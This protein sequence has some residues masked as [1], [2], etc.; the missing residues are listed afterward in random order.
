MSPLDANM[1]VMPDTSFPSTNDS[2][3]KVQFGNAPLGVGEE[4]GRCADVL[5]PH[6]PK[7]A[8]TNSQPPRLSRRVMD[9]GY[10]L[11]SPVDRADC[12]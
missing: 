7:R 3:R 9:C 4:R 11:P 1:R 6:V 2:H 10:S 5:G 8:W 12:V